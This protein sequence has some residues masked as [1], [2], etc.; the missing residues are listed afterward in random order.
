MNVKPSTPSALPPEPG[1]PGSPFAPG[2][3]LDR[4]MEVQKLE[5]LLSELTTINHGSGAIERLQRCIALA[6]ELRYSDL[7][8][9]KQPP[10]HSFVTFLTD[11]ALNKPASS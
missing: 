11:L 1:Q 4:R 5:K 6:E 7:G 9:S 10:R 3:T 8:S 2:W